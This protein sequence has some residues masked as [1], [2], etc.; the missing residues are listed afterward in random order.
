VFAVVADT[1]FVVGSGVKGYA[2]ME[3]RIADRSGRPYDLQVH[4]VVTSMEPHS[5]S[6]A[7]GTTV[8][9]TGA[10]FPTIVKIADGEVSPSSTANDVDIILPGRSKCNVQYSNSSRLVCMTEA[11]AGTVVSENNDQGGTGSSLAA[12]FR[13]LHPGARG[14]EYLL[15]YNQTELD[16]DWISQMTW[17]EGSANESLVL[18]SEFHAPRHPQ[19][20]F[21]SIHIFGKTNLIYAYGHTAQTVNILASFFVSV[22]CRS[23]LVSP[24]STRRC[25]GRTTTSST[26]YAPS[27]C[28]QSTGRTAS[29]ST[30]TTARSFG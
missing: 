13:A 27:S 2:A 8:T 22:V 29:G 5:G 19:V 24:T 11:T 26:P 28:R 4:P 30:L 7:G 12:A 6:L 23:P 15:W 20:L 14:M 17:D 1:D 16:R 3:N 18:S 25:C 10:G 21:C 9:L